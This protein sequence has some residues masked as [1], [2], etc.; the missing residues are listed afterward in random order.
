MSASNDVC[1]ESGEFGW[2]IILA[3]VA[4]VSGTMC[5]MMFSIGSDSFRRVYASEID[6]FWSTEIDDVCIENDESECQTLSVS[7]FLFSFTRLILR[8]RAHVDA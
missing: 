8:I 4:D 3:G 5:S 6:E 7:T 2:S 1:I